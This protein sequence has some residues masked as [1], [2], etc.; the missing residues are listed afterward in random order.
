MDITQRVRRIRLYNRDGKLNVSLITFFALIISTSTLFGTSDPIISDGNHLSSSIMYDLE[1]GDTFTI[2]INTDWTGTVYSEGYAVWIDFNG[3]FDFTDPGEQIAAIS[4]NQNSINSAT[5]TVPNGATVGQTRMRVSMKYNAIPSAC[6]TTFNYG[7]VEDYSINLTGEGN[8]NMC[9]LECEIAY[10]FNWYDGSTGAQW[11]ISNGEAQISNVYTISGDLG[12]YNVTVTLD[13][14]DGQ[15]ID[16]SNCTVVP[17]AAYT[18][19]CND[20]NGNRD[21]DGDPIQRILNIH[22][23]VLFLLSV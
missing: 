8:Q 6:E 11:P 4:A 22:M 16:F 15:N 18:G 9:D 17:D 5:F 12:D 20:P 1:I 2:V 7:E 13:N 19:T 3:D 10:E 23:D 14:P 21:C